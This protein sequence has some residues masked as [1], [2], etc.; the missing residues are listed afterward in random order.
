MGNKPTYR[1]AGADALLQVGVPD[2]QH[3]CGAPVLLLEVL[4][5][6]AG[7]S[8]GRREGKRGEGVRAEHNE[9]G[10]VT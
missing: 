2:A 7:G 1:S 8:I 6:V 5:P 3:L 4:V 10:V 9:R